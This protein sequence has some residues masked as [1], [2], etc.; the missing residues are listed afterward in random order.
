MNPNGWPMNAHVIAAAE[1]ADPA[2][3]EICRVS[4]TT[5][6]RLAADLPRVDFIKIDAE[7]AEESI[8][9]GMK[10]TLIRDKPLLVAEFNA[11]RCRDPY[12]FLGELRSIYGRLSYLDVHGR[13]RETSVERL[14]AD[15]RVD[16][17]LHLDDP[18]RV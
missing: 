8:L 4:R 15:S 10:Q 9:A 12:G 2:L 17:L 3:G 11:G 6:D 18:A 13:V 1:H 14:M 5:V 16:W 7:G